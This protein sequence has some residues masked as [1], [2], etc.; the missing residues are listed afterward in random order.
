MGAPGVALLCAL[1]MSIG[2]VRAA[3]IDPAE[4]RGDHTRGGA[5]VKGGEKRGRV[6]AALALSAGTIASSP[7]QHSSQT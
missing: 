3:E 1:L 7:E 6:H 5:D 2:N 4:R